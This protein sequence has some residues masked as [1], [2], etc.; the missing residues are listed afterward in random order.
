[1]GL[2]SWIITL[3]WSLWITVVGTLAS[4]ISMIVAIAQAKKAYA[5]SQN[6]KAAMA[7][8]QLAAVAERL[9]TAQEHIRDVSPDKVSLR[10]YK[11]APKIDS[12]RQEFDTALS[13]LPKVGVGSRGRELLV[14]AQGHLNSYHSSLPAEPNSS[15]WQNLQIFVQDAISE[16]KSK[17]IRTGEQQ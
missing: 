3:N 4:I 11:F 9:K 2:P 7:T 1:M 13:A 5:S 15:E 8:V 10:G 14:A 12:M 17:A 16:L 6:A